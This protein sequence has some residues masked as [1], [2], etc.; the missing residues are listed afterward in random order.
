[1]QLQE[2]DNSDNSVIIPGSSGGGSSG[3][4]KSFFDQSNLALLTLLQ[5]QEQKTVEWLLSFHSESE[6]RAWCRAFSPP[7][8][9]TA[10]S[11][12]SGG[13]GGS[14][15][16]LRPGEKI[17]ADWDC[18]EV[19]AVADYSPTSPPPVDTALPVNHGGQQDAL[20]VRAGERM[21]VLRKL[22]DTGR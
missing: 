14:G 21:K 9:T 6:R 3:G 12:S 13:D 11:D 15:A 16:G 8:A 18:P 20:D 17:Y 1:M 10:G 5:S 19:E 7:D 2:V 4:S 22:T